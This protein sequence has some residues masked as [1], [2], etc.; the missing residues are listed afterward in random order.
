ML[1]K[2]LLQIFSV[3]LA[4]LLVV[5]PAL[6]DSY[7]TVKSQVISLPISAAWMYMSDDQQYNTIPQTW[8]NINFKD[9]D[10]LYIGPA[11][12]QADGT[13]GLY[14][15]AKTGDLANR[16]KW[17]IQT[18]RS[19]N[20][21]IKI[22]VSQWWGNGDGIWGNPLNSLNTEAAISKYTDS[23]AAFLQSYLSVSGGVDG[24]DIDYE[25]NNVVS[26]ISTITSQ[27]RTKMDALSKENGGRPFYLTVSPDTTS[28]LSTAVA[29]LDFVN[30]QTYDAGYYLTAQDFT[31]VGL[32]SKQLL[33]GTCPETG[34]SNPPV[35]NSNNQCDATY[36]ACQAECAYTD[37][38]LAGIPLA[39]IHLW[40]LNSGNYIY[41]DQV[42]AQIYS[43]LHQQ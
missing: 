43:F 22:I 37:D 27:I 31:N 41:E 21:N 12:V 11:G 14:S 40:R 5:S 38:K 25:D 3:A 36:E 26:S 32:E 30:M 18:A 33:Y 6:A 16:F 34:C 19:Q 4:F 13:F 35:C 15:S 17:I 29:W 1:K 20:P 7:P 9:V 39:G 23:V 28:Y 2:W 42:Q 8:S 10:V 24:Y